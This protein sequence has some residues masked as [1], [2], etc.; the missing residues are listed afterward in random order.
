MARNG[1]QYATRWSTLYANDA[2]YAFQSTTRLTEVMAVTHVCEVFSLATLGQKTD[3][4][5]LPLPGTRTQRL[6]NE[7]AAQTYV[8]TKRLKCLGGASVRLPICLPQV[9]RRSNFAF[10]A[11]HGYS[12]DV[13]QQ[14]NHSSPAGAEG[15]V[16]SKRVLQGSPRM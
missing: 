3:K 6:P 9:D 7:V 2:A 11:L 4:M 1:L 8:H 16:A 12:C 10:G 13:V 15:A 5:P 14:N